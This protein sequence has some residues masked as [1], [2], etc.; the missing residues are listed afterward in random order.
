M[1]VEANLAK[2]TSI[3]EWYWKKKEKYQPLYAKIKAN[4]IAQINEIA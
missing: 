3:M 2:A 4:K 1:G